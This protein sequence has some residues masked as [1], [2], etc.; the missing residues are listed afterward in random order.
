MSYHPSSPDDES[1]HKRFH[2]KSV[3]GI[4]FA[5]SASGKKDEPRAVWK[6]PDDAC[7]VMIDRK[8]CER[9]KRKAR[10]VLEVVDSELSSA[11]VDEETLWSEGEKF[12]IFLY[13]LG[14]KCVGLLLAER[15][16][17]AYRVVEDGEVEEEKVHE[18]SSVSVSY[19]F[20]LD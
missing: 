2:S 10:E 18:G 12:K 3:G 16:Q 8:S 11:E 15:I 17:R 6:G 1:L 20:P 14:K 4:L 19:V 13:V 7:V 5:L 9:E